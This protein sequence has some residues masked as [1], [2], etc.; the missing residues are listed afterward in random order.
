M[1]GVL[2]DPLTLAAV[3]QVSQPLVTQGPESIAQGPSIPSFEPLP[4]G[5]DFVSPTDNALPAASEPQAQPAQPLA[6]PIN[7]G[8]P[9][10]AAKA[11]LFAAASTLPLV[12]DARITSAS[13]APFG[14]MENEGL[15]R[16]FRV[17]L[18]VDALSMTTVVEFIC[19]S[20]DTPEIFGAEILSARILE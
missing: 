19:R 8:Q 13:A 2:S 15:Y 3:A 11:C 18:I 10:P 7:P 4:P 9:G 5:A 16:D 14:S 6:S 17:I 1:F 20:A 12:P